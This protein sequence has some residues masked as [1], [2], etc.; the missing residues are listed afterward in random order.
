MLNFN[1]QKWLNF[2]QTKTSHHTL[3]AYQQDAA[4]FSNFLKHHFGK[5]ITQEDLKHLTIRDVRSWL[6]SRQSTYDIRST[7]RAFSCI[8]NLFQFLI[9]E[10]HIE[11]SP[12]SQMRAPKVKKLLPKP[13]SIEQVFDVIQNLNENKDM[14]INKRDQAFFMLVYSVGLRIQEALNLNQNMLDQDFFIVLGKGNKQRS[15]PLMANVKERIK[16]YLSICPYT[17]NKDAPLFYSQKGKRLSQGIMQ[18]TLKT[19]RELYHLP[20]YATPHAL[21]HSCATH[22]I[23]KTDNLRAVQDLLGHKSLSTTQIYTKISQ[24]KI[25]KDYNKAHPCSV[26]EKEI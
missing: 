14:W 5:E 3:R 1:I 7:A 4:H 18:K 22:L 12:F 24:E 23:D 25:K 19:Y 10:K 11:Y 2:I 26:K 9:L 20:D 15:L 16:S 6:S 13:L 21:R 17:L 8:K